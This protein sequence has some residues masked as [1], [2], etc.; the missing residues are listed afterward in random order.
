MALVSQAGAEILKN[1]GSGNL[2]KVFCHFNI[3]KALN[4]VVHFLPFASFYLSLVSFKKNLNI[5][6]IC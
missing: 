6:F 4:V 3:L 2:G 1:A 5:T